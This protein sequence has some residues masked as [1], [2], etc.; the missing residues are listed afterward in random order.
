VT[1]VLG[2]TRPVDSVSDTV[3]TDPNLADVDDMLNGHWEI[4]PV[5]DL[6]LANPTYSGGTLSARN[7]PF[8]TNANTI[9][10]QGS[11]QTAHST[12]TCSPSSF[13][14]QTLLGRLFNLKTD[15]I[16][17]VAVDLT[18]QLIVVVTDP[19]SGAQTSIFLDALIA[20]RVRGVMADFNGDGYDDLFVVA[21]G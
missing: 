18:C 19:T 15:V 3:T 12:N 6:V 1:A 7:F 16:I 14:Q 21:Q 9:S 4:A 13:P 10:S 5:D 11:T 20:G 8:Y 17:T 2:V